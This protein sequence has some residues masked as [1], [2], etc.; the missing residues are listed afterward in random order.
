MGPPA[1]KISGGFFAEFVRSKIRARI[2]DPAV[3]EKLVPKDVVELVKAKAKGKEIA[4][5][6]NRYRCKDGTYRWLSWTSTP[7]LDEQLIYAVAHDTT[8]RKLLEQ[9]TQA[10]GTLRFAGVVERLAVVRI[11]PRLE[12][13]P[14]HL[15]GVNDRDGERQALANA[16]RK[17]GRQLIDVV[18]E[19]ELLDEGGNA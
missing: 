12:Q 19:P 4:L 5:F 7:K 1:W 9:Q 8:D 13:Q 18:A 2:K 15:R 10:L 14:R 17:I 3:A 6:E 16:E 11:R